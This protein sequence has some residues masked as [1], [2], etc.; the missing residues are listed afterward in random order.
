ALEFFNGL[1]GFADDGRDYVT[2]LGEGQSTP[3]PWV[4]VVANE[5]FGFQVSAEGSGYTWSVNSRQHQITPWS[6]DPIGDRP[7]EVIYLRDEDTGALWCP[8]ALPIRNEGSTYT[9]RHG[10]GY[11]RF[12]HTAHDIGVELVQFVPL[13]DPIKISRLKIHNHSAQTRRLSITAYVEWALGTSRDA[14]AQFV[15]TEIDADTGVM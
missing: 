14:S 11:S 12:E 5:S 6:N 13:D 15:T 4:N 7:G 10:Q 9:A 2:I 8:T 1:G 3:A